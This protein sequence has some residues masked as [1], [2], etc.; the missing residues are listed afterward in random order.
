MNENF[1]FVDPLTKEPLIKKKEGFYNNHKKKYPKNDFYIDFR[2]DT[3]NID[4]FDYYQFNASSYD[5]FN[6]LT[7]K[8]QGYNETEVRKYS[9]SKLGNIPSGKNI[10]EIGSGTGRDS[11]LIDKLLKKNTNFFLLDASDKMLKICSEKLK[12]KNINKFFILADACFSPFQDESFDFI[13][14]FV[15]LPAISNKKDFFNEIN[16]VLKPGGKVV[17]G[18]EGILPSIKNT[19]FGKIL[20]NN[21]DLYNQH[22]PLNILHKNFSNVSIE[23]ILNDIIFLLSFTKL[24]KKRKIK[25]III[26][27]KRGGS[28]Y[29]R[30]YGK[31]E[32]VKAE[33][34]ELVHKILKKNNLSY[35]EWLN[36][37]IIE[38]AKKEL[39][40][41]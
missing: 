31:L 23:W 12:N 17:L 27:G 32:G 7:F 13:Y 37:T 10:L 36:K 24:R 21:S 28:L 6:D 33:T 14:S 1:F 22:I 18:S 40:D 4:W 16:R 25:D 30:Y 26:P 29:T 41:E 15:T 9:I 38:T 11:V 34:K 2:I 20:L 39:N 8:L 3:K 5:S 19:N 35:Y